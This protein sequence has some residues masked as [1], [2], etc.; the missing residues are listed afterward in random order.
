MFARLQQAVSKPREVSEVTQFAENVVNFSSQYGTEGST[1]YVAANLAGSL[2]VYN[3]YGDFVEAFVLVCCQIPCCFAREHRQHK[4]SIDLQQA[5][6]PQ[7]VAVWP[8]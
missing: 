3:R 5:A 1:S 8:A 2:R 7:N 4:S 6:P